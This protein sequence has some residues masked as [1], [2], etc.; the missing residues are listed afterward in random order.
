MDKREKKGTLLWKKRTRKGK[1]IREKGTPDCPAEH[2]HVAKVVKN[3]HRMPVE[4]IA[5]GQY[6]DKRKNIGTKIQGQP[7]RNVHEKCLKIQ[8]E[9]NCSYQLPKRQRNKENHLETLGK[10]CSLSKAEPPT[11]KDP[12]RST[13]LN[14]RHFFKHHANPKLFKI[15]ECLSI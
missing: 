14:S 1:R 12:H 10:D 9:A 15:S 13:K 6:G 4:T 5:N 7:K 8:C 2:E 3:T 11:Q